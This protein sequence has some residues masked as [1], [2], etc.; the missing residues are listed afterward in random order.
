MVS[1]MRQLKEGTDAADIGEVDASYP[2]KVY[3]VTTVGGRRILPL[4][5]EEQLPRIC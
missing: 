5:S 3:L 2:G 4:L 1:F